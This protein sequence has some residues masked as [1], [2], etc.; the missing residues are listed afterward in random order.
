MKNTLQL[1]LLLLTT[2]FFA[3]NSSSPKP[4]IK[5]YNEV[6][7]EFSVIYPF[8]VISLGCGVE[9]V[10]INAA[11]ITNLGSPDSYYIEQIPYSSKGYLPTAGTHVFTP[12]EL[13]VPGELI[14]F[15]IDDHWGE[16]KSLSSDGSDLDFC[17]F[18]NSQNQF[19][20][21]TNGVLSFDT[22][23]ANSYSDWNLQ[24]MDRI[25]PN[26]NLGDNKD[27]ILQINDVDPSSADALFDSYM[28]WS[29]VGGQGER[30]FT[31]GTHRMPMYACNGD[32]GYATYQTVFYETTN[33]IEFH[34]QDKP[35]CDTWNGG[36]QA[37]GIQNADQTVGFAL[38]GF[39][40]L[41][42]P[43]QILDLNDGFYDTNFNPNYPVHDSVSY[44][45]IPDGVNGV[46]PEFGWYLNWDSVTNTGT[47][48]STNPILNVL[49]DDIPEG[50][51]ITYT[52]VVKYT[53]Y[54]SG[55]IYY[56]TN[57]VTFSNNPIQMHIQEQ[58]STDDTVE[59]IDVEEIGICTT[60]DY[61][62]TAIIQNV[63][64]SLTYTIE[65][66]VESLG[67]PTTTIQTNTITADGNIS[68]LI[69]SGSL[70][71][72][73]IY[74][75]TCT[76]TSDT[77][78]FSDSVVILAQDPIPA[79]EGNSPV[80][81]C[82]DSLTLADL[83]I[84]NTVGY[85]GIYWYSTETQESGTELPES[86]LLD[87]GTTYYAFQAICGCGNNE[88]LGVLPITVNIIENIPAPIGEED[89]VF[90]MNDNLMLSSI[91]LI[92][93]DG[94]D[95]IYWFSEDNSSGIP[96]DPSIITEDETTYYAFQGIGVCSTSL[97]VTVHFAT[98]LGIND[99]QV[100]NFSINPN[101]VRDI[102]N[103]KFENINNKT[104]I[105]VYNLF[106]SLVYKNTFYQKNNININISNLNK[107][108][109][110][111]QTKMDSKTN[112]KKFIKL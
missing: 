59:F 70:T 83:I 56:A 14:D 49:Q 66:T 31:L 5:A 90:C 18:G 94:F 23:Y 33:I 91:G 82:D 27:A 26:A 89:W 103:I 100:I 95:S 44:R 102:L 39:D 76:I 45:L 71:P 84:F 93:T 61:P 110:F 107:G 72:N 75:Y 30:F 69:T 35:I 12:A 46:T 25:Y 42:D 92:N 64:T 86:T 77:C 7:G 85:D 28:F 57:E 65:W 13:G 36:Y 11:F 106:G 38:P 112:T 55:D 16:I 62:I 8:D 2:T 81:L 80:N 54:C 17:F 97:A 109:Y 4:I 37:F 10:Q 9:N 60:T 88:C 104:S 111:I 48:V 108:V 79:P 43:I 99:N 19:V 24:N 51:N 68:Y 63:D 15:S 78:I 32:F 67:N 53:E 40:N 98:C 41:G 52:A 101:P 50:I 34:I 3:Q 105:K 96:L 74:T 47:L 6:T 20:V 73:V 21:S 58:N 87:N 22:S 29:I 1:L